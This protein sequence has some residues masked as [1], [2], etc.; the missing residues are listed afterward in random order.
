MNEPKKIGKTENS[1]YI[2]GYLLRMGTEM[3]HSQDLVKGRNGLTE[4]SHNLAK[5]SY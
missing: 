5:V 4:G 2:Q 1:Q 3:S